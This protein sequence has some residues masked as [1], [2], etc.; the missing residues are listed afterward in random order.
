M[1]KLLD[2]DLNVLK[3]DFYRIKRFLRYKIDGIFSPDL[4]LLFYTAILIKSRNLNI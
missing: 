2:T 3:L 4:A 1:N